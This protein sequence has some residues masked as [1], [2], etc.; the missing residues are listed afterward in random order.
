MGDRAARADWVG[1]WG[2]GREG[3]R[4]ASE[5]GGADTV[6]PPSRESVWKAGTRE[7]EVGPTRP[8]GRGRGGCGLV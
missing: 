5:W 1:L 4:R 3:S 8:K 6:V 2:I 7:G